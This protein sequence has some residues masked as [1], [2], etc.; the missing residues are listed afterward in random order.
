M[1]ASRSTHISAFSNSKLLIAFLLVTFLNISIYSESPQPVRSKH[2]MVVSASTIASK[3]GVEIMKKGGNAIDA[4]VAVGFALAVTYPYAGNIGGG[5][6]MVIHLKNGKNLAIDFR[7]KAPLAATRNMYL[8]E[9]GNYVSALS[10]EGTTSAG[11]PGS[12]AGLLY[13]LNKYGT[14]KISDVIQPAIDL[15]NNGW[16]LNY[17]DIKSF[18][19]YLPEFEK[20]PSSYKVFTNNGVAYKEGEL[21]TQ[22]DLART[23]E[24][25]KENGRDGFYKGRVAELLIKQIQSMG[26]I[27]TQSD[28]DEY[29]PVERKPVTGNYRGYEIV[30]MP[31]PSSGGIALVQLLN[32]L[33]NYTFKF[34]DWASSEYINKIVEA[35]KYVYADRTYH[36]GD[37]DFYPVPKSGLLSKEYAKEIFEKIE[38]NKSRAVPSTEISYGEPSKYNESMETTHYSIYDS[39]GN[40]VSTTTTLNS[41]FGSKIVVDGAGFLLN[42]EMDDFSAKPGV[43][44][45]FGL[46]GSEANSIQPGKRMLSS[47]TP[48]IVLKDDKPYMVIGSPGG[49]T[50]ITVVLQVIIN[51]IDFKMNIQEA[52]DMPRIHHQ[53]LP[54]TLYYEKFSLSKDVKNNLI[55]MGYK[56]EDRE[57]KYRILGMAEGILIDDIKKII[58]GASDPRGRGSAEGY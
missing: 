52:I 23:L 53:W 51:C 8:D 15:A 3:I 21:F 24:Q 38:A 36:L 42:N 12:V 50:I 27:I 48:T 9:D 19:N 11:V 6:F 37:E 30:S 44:N 40:A 58:L 20:Y 28:L 18:D 34:D 47:M 57:K 49:S 7:E 46:L 39:E 56:L 16:I 26:G 10:Q 31:P 41:A 29:Q 1:K 33:G 17:K 55:K 4:A 2:G 43:P 25:I 35:M 13:A 54:D 45:Q 14:L 22:P 5:G 32:I